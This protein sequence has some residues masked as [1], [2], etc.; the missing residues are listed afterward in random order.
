[1]HCGTLSRAWLLTTS[2]STTSSLAVPT[3]VTPP[4]HWTVRVPAASTAHAERRLPDFAQEL[5]FWSTPSPFG[6][7][8]PR[9]GAVVPSVV[10]LK[11]LGLS[12]K[13]LGL[14][15]NLNLNLADTV[16]AQAAVQSTA[17]S[18]AVAGAVAGVAATSRGAPPDPAA[19]AVLTREMIQSVL[20][21]P[22]VEA[23]K[24]CGHGLTMV[25]KRQ[26]VLPRRISPPDPLHS[27][28]TS[29]PSARDRPLAGAQAE[30]H[31]ARD[32]CLRGSVVAEHNPRCSNAA[33]GVGRKAGTDRGARALTAN[34]ARA[35]HAHSVMIARTA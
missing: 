24:A 32:C 6:P 29:M 28:Q 11:G 13:V 15:L 34:S 23:A 9:A 31:A 20:H 7:V 19:R 26:F 17:V 14:G 10:S 5:G 27:V 3:S 21:M 18:G 12:L 35:M 16:T 2:A 4:S 22:Q 30:E 8:S 25:R 33:V 1:M